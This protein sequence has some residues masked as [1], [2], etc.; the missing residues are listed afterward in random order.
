MN[1]DRREKMTTWLN[2]TAFAK[3]IVNI[4]RNAYV[5][6]GSFL[7]GVAEINRVTNDGMAVFR[8]LFAYPNNVLEEL[9]EYDGRGRL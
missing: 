3:T 2:E 6:S 9:E 7:K 4:V 1:A 8:E 5:K